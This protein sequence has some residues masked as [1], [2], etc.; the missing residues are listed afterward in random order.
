MLTPTREEVMK[1]VRDHPG[2]EADHK[3]IAD[4]VFLLLQYPT[5]YVESVTM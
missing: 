3:T 4:L 5:D 1:L 2:T